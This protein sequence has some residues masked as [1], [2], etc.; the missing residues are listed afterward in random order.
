[1]ADMIITPAARS[2]VPQIWDAEL[3]SEYVRSNRFM[4]YMGT[5]AGAM[6]QVKK[7]LTRKRGDTIT[8]AAR[9]KLVGAG[10]TGDTLLEGA[11]EVLDTHGMKLTVQPIRHAV[12]VTD[13]QEQQSVVDLR[14]AAR[15]ALKDWA[16]EKMRTDII[17]SFL[18]L[19]GAPIATS[20]AANSNAWLAANFDRVL[21]GGARSNNTGVFSTSLANVGP[22]T[23]VP[24][25]MG[26][27]VIS[28]AKR[29]AKT[30]KPTI[31]PIT[32]KGDQEWY[33]AFMPSLAFRDLQADPAI[34]TTYQYAADRGKDNILF[35][36]DDIVIA[37]VICREIPEMPIL[38][39]VGAGGGD[40]APWVLCGAQ[41]LGVA[42][43]QTLQSTTN[44]RDYKF[45]HGVGIS[46]IRGI[47]KL[48]FGRTPGAETN[49][50]DQG[51]LT[52]FVSGVADG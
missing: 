33:V 9:R 31:R 23:T 46:E 44:E 51:M 32:V 48:A 42:W 29:L 52:G 49:L 11:E 4:R 38:T 14:S 16:M 12:A 39:G 15:D 19:N 21:F 6:I 17:S 30:A 28:L 1:M 47:G 7:D 3:F 43:A 37:G 35:T 10:V 27:A 41:A 2:L 50:V 20:S 25:K 34:Q 18:S 36:D 8:F 45:R 40:V 22:A 13:W 26:K 24:G 5:D